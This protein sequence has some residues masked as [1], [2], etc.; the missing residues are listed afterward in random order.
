MTICEH[1][2][3]LLFIVQMSS[4]GTLLILCHQSTTKDSNAMLRRVHPSHAQG[5]HCF[6]LKLEQSD[7]VLNSHWDKLLLMNVTW[8]DSTQ[9]WHRGPV[10]EY[11]PSLLSIGTMVYPL[12]RALIRNLQEILWVCPSSLPEPQRTCFQV[13]TIFGVNLI[14]CRHERLPRSCINHPLAEHWCEFTQKTIH[15]GNK[16][17]GA[18]CPFVQFLT[19]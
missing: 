13:T 3:L 11:I 9:F 12:E 17:P 6:F 16:G 14:H 2:V 5:N 10:N 18:I 1:V 15:V 4:T 19:G 7:L 8:C